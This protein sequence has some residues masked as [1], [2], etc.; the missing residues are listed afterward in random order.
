M[1]MYKDIEAARDELRRGARVFCKRFVHCIECKNPLDGD[2][3]QNYAISALRRAMVANELDKMEREGKKEGVVTDPCDS[4]YK[5]VI[6]IGHD[7]TVTTE[8]VGKM[9]EE[10]L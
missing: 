4:T 10:A 3:E 7:G 1:K 6:R 5:V 8:N 9:K 2:R